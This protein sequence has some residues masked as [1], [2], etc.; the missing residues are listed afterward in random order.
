MAK[1]VKTKYEGVFSYEG[2]TDTTFYIVYYK[3]DKRTEEAVGR[4][5]RDQMTAA[6]ANHIRSLRVTGRQLSNTEVRDAK[7][8]EDE[9]EANRWTFNRLW[10]HYHQNR[11]NYKG[12]NRDNSVFLNHIAPV[13]GDKEPHL[14]DP[15]EIDRLKLGLIKK[16]KLSAQTV[17]N[18]LELIRRLSN[19]GKKRR[20]T[21][22]L[23]FSISMPQP[24]NEVKED[25]PP[26]LVGSLLEAIKAADDQLEACFIKMCLFTGRRT[27]EICKLQWSDINLGQQTM[28]LRNTKTNRDELLPLADE[29]KTMLASMDRFSEIWL[30]PNH[31]GNERKR[32]D[33][34]GRRIIQAAGIPSSY[35]PTYCLRHTF[36]STAASLGIPWHVIKELLGHKS[37]SRDITDRYARVSQKVLLQSVN[38]VADHFLETLQDN[39]DTFKSEA[40]ISN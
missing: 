15:L 30:F 38:Q 34:P 18:V 11:D 40:T 10:E 28:L 12:F 25:L 20:L 9:L 33:S 35:R 32:L 36:A 22:G 23:S 16:Q 29:L 13:L 2:A 31:N 6:K 39:T 37:G 7:K 3:G 14:V 4:A 8:A 19:W 17:K 27:G 1:R 21:L 26:E 24:N 5:T